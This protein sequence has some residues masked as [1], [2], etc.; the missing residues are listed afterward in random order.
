MVAKKA[1]MFTSPE[2]DFAPLPFHP[3]LD[4]Y[5]KNAFLP[6]TLQEAFNSGFD[7]PLI[8]GH[9][10]DEG[11]QLLTKLLANTTKIDHYVQNWSKIGPSMIFHRIQEDFP[12]NFSQAMKLI[13]QK[14]FG[15]EKGPKD[16]QNFAENFGQMY[17]DSVY[18]AG[19]HL[20][21]KLASENAQVYQYLYSH[22]GSL[23]MAEIVHLNFW[24]IL[25]KFFGRFI[26][27]DLY[28]SKYKFASHSD[29][30]LLIFNTNSLPFD[31]AFTEQ[32]KKVS[33]HLLTLWTDFVKNEP[34]KNWT[35]LNRNNPKRLEISTQGLNII[36]IDS[37]LERFWTQHIWP[38]IGLVIN[39]SKINKDEL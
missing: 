20:I 15:Q 17:S 8:I 32:D 3:V 29:D 27:L 25:S 1:F 24:Q 33:Q 6:L 11:A 21:G 39:N 23:S 38:K 4:S 14:Y 26:G 9:N 2:L 18:A 7:V 22:A 10:R 28:P 30:Q 19:V 35:R 31:G 12:P 13:N 34:L 5:S 36:D 16:V 37:D